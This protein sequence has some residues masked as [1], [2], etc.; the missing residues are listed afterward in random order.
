RCAAEARIPYPRDAPA[1]RVA[2]CRTQSDRVASVQ[3]RVEGPVPAD[4]PA[5]PARHTSDGRR[6]TVRVLITGATGFT[7]GHLARKLAAAGRD[8]RALV[9]DRSRAAP[10]ATAGIDLAVGDLL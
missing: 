8:V 1:V 9:R 6:R 4:W 7:G 3:P 5:R 2:D 10:L